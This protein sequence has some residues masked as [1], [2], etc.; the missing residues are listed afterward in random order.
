[1]TGIGDGFERRL[2]ENKVENLASLAS[3]QPEELAKTLEVSEVRAMAFVDQ[4]R[5][6]L[7]QPK[8]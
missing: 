4:A 5:E 3:M 7:K 8:E 1:M 2:T 6:L